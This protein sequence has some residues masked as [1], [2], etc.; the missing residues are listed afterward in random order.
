MAGKKRARRVSF[1]TVFMLLLTAAVLAGCVLF[2]AMIL[3]DD[4]YTR[5]GELIRT[6]SQEDIFEQVEVVRQT[7]APQRRVTFIEDTPTPVPAPTATPVPQKSTIRIAV[8]GAVYVPKAVREGAQDGAGYDFEPAFGGLKGAFSGA[9]LCI[10]T[11][12]TVTAGQRLGLD[13]YNAPP[14]LLDALRESG[15]DLLALATERALDKGYEGLDLTVSELTQRGLAYAGLNP[16]SGSRATMMSIGGV[17]VAVLSY[18]YGLSES[19]EKATHS[20]ARGAVARMNAEAMIQDVRQARVDGANLVIVLPHW[21]TKNK[22][23]TADTIRLLARRLAEAGADV[24]LGT[25]PNIVQKTERLSVTR[26]D[27]LTYETVVCYSLGCLM[28][29]SRAQENTA[30]MIAQLEVTYDPVTRHTSLGE[31]ACVPVYIARERSEGK[32]VFRAVDAR[33]EGALSQLDEGERANAAAAAER[34]YEAVG[35]QAGG[36]R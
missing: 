28:T 27:G 8:G 33:D 31:L 7:P 5:T 13:S 18:T 6:L 20:D 11:L 34:V 30:G 21:G 2:L 12:E 16:E 19:G 17:Q 32:N 29:D 36:Q 24:I 22:Q 4:V 25:H 26:S 23:D 10:A 3:G 1:G 35:K 15:V 14:Q 9:D